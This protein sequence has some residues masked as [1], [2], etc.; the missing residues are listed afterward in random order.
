MHKSS[1]ITRQWKIALTFCDWYFPILSKN[2][3]GG[4]WKTSFLPHTLL[5]P[6][7]SLA[8]LRRTA[9]ICPIQLAFK[10]VQLSAPRCI[11]H[12][13]AITVVCLHFSSKKIKKKIVNNQVVGIVYIGNYCVRLLR[14]RLFRGRRLAP[15]RRGL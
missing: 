8:I 14:K 3:L 12:L 7:L 15:C 13:Y 1:V 10:K 5:T 11:H 6:R 2:W 9:K 4:V